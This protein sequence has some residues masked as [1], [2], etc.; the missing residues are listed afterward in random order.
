[1][2]S[3]QNL[4]QSQ[5]QN[6]LQNQSS[7]LDEHIFNETDLV[8][9]TCKETNEVLYNFFAKELFQ[10]LKENGIKDYNNDSILFKD[11]G[12]FINIYHN[13]PY[14][15]DDVQVDSPGILSKHLIL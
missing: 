5:N 12:K 7:P 1:M 13:L 4:Y 11:T 14:D 6:S 10:W 2:Q 9:L 8:A 3:S 15:A